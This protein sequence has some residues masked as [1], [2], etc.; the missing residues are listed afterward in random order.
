MYATMKF[1]NF[2]EMLATM[3]YALEHLPA[4]HNSEGSNTCAGIKLGWG[5][6]GARYLSLLQF[7]MCL[8]FRNTTSSR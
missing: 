6:A 4:Y 7:L 2:L 1:V 3:W 8:A 5:G